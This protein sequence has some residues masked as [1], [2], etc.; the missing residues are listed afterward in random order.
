MLK[1]SELSKLFYELLNCSKDVEKT[2]GLLY[3]ILDY[4]TRLNLDCLKQNDKYMIETLAK[5]LTSDFASKID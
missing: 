2:S 3:E 1:L 5:V 4:F